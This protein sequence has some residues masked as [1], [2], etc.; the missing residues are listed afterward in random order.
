MQ[1][2]R[3]C[4][5]RARAAAFVFLPVDRGSTLSGRTPLGRSPVYLR[6]LE[7]WQCRDPAFQS[8]K[9]RLSV[10]VRLLIPISSATTRG[11]LSVSKKPTI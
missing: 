2:R 7:A 9:A 1:R 3:V 5:A 11:L 6:L 10:A 8:Q 4:S